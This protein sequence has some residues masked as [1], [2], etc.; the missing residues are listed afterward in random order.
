[1]GFNKGHKMEE[2]RLP[3]LIGYCVM[4]SKGRITIPHKERKSV[5]GYL[6][7]KRKDMMLLVDPRLVGRKEGGTTK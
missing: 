1:M 7:Y 3:K 4:D 5:T 6:V 2:E